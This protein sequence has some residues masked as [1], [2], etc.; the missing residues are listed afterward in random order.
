[1]THQLVL[2]DRTNG[3]P[4]DQTLIMEW[5]EGV[6]LTPRMLIAERVRI[7]WEARE[8]E[9]EARAGGRLGPLVDD[10]MMR[11]L[12]PNRGTSAPGQ[13]PAPPTLP[14]LES[15]TALALDGFLRNAFFLVVDGQQATD[16]DA[17][18][19]L[20]P[21]SDVTFVRLVPLKGG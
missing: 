17:E 9:R 20:R 14:T 11:R 15:A 3:R 5:Q 13:A 21:T 19:A 2:S 7:E 12:N 8:A 18:I 4:P 1:M 16:L 6:P 10:A